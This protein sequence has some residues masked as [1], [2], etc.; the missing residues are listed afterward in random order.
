[1]AK[2]AGPRCNLRC[3]YCFY[4]KKKQLYP[5]SALQMSEE[6]M[7]RYI[8]QTV[9]SHPGSDITI[10]WQG[11]EPTLMGIQ[12][13]QRAI[14]VQKKLS[15]A[16]I[17]IHNTLQTN[18]TIIDERWCEFFRDNN[19]LVGLSMDGP[20]VFHDCFRK[21]WQGRSVFARVMQ[22]AKLMKQ[23][24]V[25]FN[26][27]CTVN[28]I[29]SCHPLEVYRFFRDELEA[30][31]LQFIPIV[32]R[33]NS[34]GEQKGTCITKR[35][36]QPEM[37]GNFLTTIFDEWVHRDVG[38]M[39]VQFFDAVLASYVYGFSTLCVL[40]PT[41]GL[42]V[43]LEHNGD[44]YSCDHFVEPE[45]LLG[46]IK[47]TSIETLVN[48]E[49]QRNFGIAKSSTLPND[50]KQCEFLFTCHGECPKNRIFDAPD[51]SGKINWLC[52]GLLQ[53]FQH[54]KNH[55][56]TMASLLNA[57]KDACEIMRKEAEMIPELLT[58]QNRH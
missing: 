12:F 3:D 43:V 39:F 15:T 52:S 38:T 11:G 35:S 44:I 42:N 9:R 13:Y 24:G 7:Q 53:F 4:L 8:H 31:Y 16:G 2:P 19:I 30:H 49:K 26:I 5:E 28:A 25:E 57:G 6:I 40:Q 29:N 10:A 56:Q 46:N 37:F 51:G 1:M 33:D 50:C 34:A 20:Q 47:R 18:G 22:T 48:Y 23:F 27:L 17:R 21:D 36:V 14:S 41:C 32:E 58:P 55:M 54:T 45:Y